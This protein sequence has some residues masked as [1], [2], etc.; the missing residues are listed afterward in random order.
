MW[1]SR[2]KSGVVDPA[3]GAQW[4]ANRMD[5]FPVA[6]HKVEPLR[7][8]V[9]NAERA[10][11][12]RD[13]RAALEDVDRADVE[14][15]LRPLGVEEPRVRWAQR[16]VEAPAKRPLARGRLAGRP[17]TRAW[18]APFDTLPIRPHRGKDVHHHA[19]L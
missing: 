6:G 9:A 7:D 10:T 11:A 2:S 16:L 17:A 1:R 14:R 8:R 3:R 12:A 15:G 19:P 5:L 4:E 18:L 13:A